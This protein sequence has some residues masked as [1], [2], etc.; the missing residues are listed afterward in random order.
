MSLINDALKKAQK[1]RTGESPPLAAMPG[2]GGQP[3]ARI[4]HRTKPAAYELPYLQIGAGLG[5]AIVLVVGGVY[6]GRFLKSDPAESSP[7]K[8]ASVAKA[9]PKTEA[10]PPAAKPAP[11][12]ATTF[13]L[14]IAA[15]SSNPAPLIAAAAAD[16]PKPVAITLPPPEPEPVK[17]TVPPKFETKG[18]TFIESLR[19]AGIR[20]SAT[21][22]KVLMNDRVYRVGDTVEHEMGI[23]IIGITASSLS[24]ED[25]NGA[26]YTRNF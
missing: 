8:P 18:I 9:A 16:T 7:A 19:V 25:Q 21:D 2:V 6:L 13:V 26:R 22:S 14:P 11:S 23:K 24:F 15:P 17:P 1:Q 5:L 4:A 20:A 10:A 3:A 12:S